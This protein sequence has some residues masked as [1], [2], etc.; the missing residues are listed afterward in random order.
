MTIPQN[1]V[2][3]GPSLKTDEQ[4]KKRKQHPDPHGPAVSFFLH[5]KAFSILLDFCFILFY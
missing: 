1:G 5:G 2:M 3:R 4:K